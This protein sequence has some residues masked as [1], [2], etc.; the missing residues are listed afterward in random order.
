MPV[1]GRLSLLP[2]GFAALVMGCTPTLDWRQ[3]RPENGAMALLL[4]CKPERRTRPVVLADVSV[5]VEVLACGAGGTTWG[6]TS[7]DLGEAARVG[8][9]LAALR[10]ARSINLEGRETEA[11]VVAIAELASKPPPLRL[12]VEGRMPDGQPVVEHS[13]LFARGSQVFHAA[14]LGGA[15]SADALDT[16]FDSLE[17]AR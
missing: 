7:A 1:I 11:R 6:L 3:V 16:F 2:L 13:L 14:A 10:A 5:A 15:P 17:P 12:R 9:A 4:P 8:P